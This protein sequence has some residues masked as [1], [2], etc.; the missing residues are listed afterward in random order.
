MAVTMTKL[1]QSG[2]TL[3]FP[4]PHLSCWDCGERSLIAGKLQQT[5]EAFMTRIAQ[6]TT[7][8]HRLEMGRPCLISLK[9]REGDG[10]GNVPFSL[11]EQQIMVAP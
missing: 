7:W 9:R 1:G 3:R 8:Q 4:R 6:M 2:L 10:R 11:V 5:Q